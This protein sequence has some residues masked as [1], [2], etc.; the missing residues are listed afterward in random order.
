MKLIIDGANLAV[1]KELY[2]YFPIDGVTCNPTILAQEKRNPYDVLMEIRDF[3]GPND[4]LHVQVVSSEADTMYEEAHMIRKRLGAGTFIKVP[5]TREG[6]RV[7]KMLKKEG[8]PV[9]A[10]AIYTHMQAFLAAKAGADYAAPYINRIDNL[11][12]DGIREAREIHDIFRNNHLSCEVLAASFKNVQQALELAKYGI[13]AATISPDVIEGLVRIDAVDH[14]VSV[15]RKD[16]ESF[17]GEGANMK[18]V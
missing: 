3:I 7:I 16:F 17:C 8:F 11:G 5:V 14:A 10:T 12:V 6:M 13:G 15:F 4:E 2:R 18:N 9:T 1:I